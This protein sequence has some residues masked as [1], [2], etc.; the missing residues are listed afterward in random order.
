MVKHG[1]E[2]LSETMSGV[3]EDIYNSSVLEVSLGQGSE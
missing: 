1:L 2:I 3:K